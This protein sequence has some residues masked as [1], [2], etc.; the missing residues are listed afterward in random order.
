M[1]NKDKLTILSI[2]YQHV[3]WGMT[4]NSDGVK[5]YK[6]LIHMGFV[7]KTVIHKR[8]FVAQDGTHT[9]YTENVWSNLKAHL[10]SIHGSQ[11]AM[12]DGHIDEFVLQIQ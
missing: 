2:T 1:Q 7:H 6:G 5:V 3:Q 12:L 8:E 9:N 11:G 10:K 4:I